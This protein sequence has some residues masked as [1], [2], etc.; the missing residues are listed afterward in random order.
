MYML[1]KIYACSQYQV[2]ANKVW[3]LNQKLNISENMNRSHI[4]IIHPN[5]ST[6]NSDNV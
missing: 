4:K 2:E 5:K 1:V 6:P 3:Q